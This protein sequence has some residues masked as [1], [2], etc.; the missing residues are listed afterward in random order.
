MRLKFDTFMTL[1]SQRIHRLCHRS[2]TW[3]RCFAE[4]IG[5]IEPETQFLRQRCRIDVWRSRKELVRLAWRTEK[6]TTGKFYILAC[7]G[8]CHETVVI[9]IWYTTHLAM[10]P[11][12]A[13][14]DSNPGIVAESGVEKVN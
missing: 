8:S 9:A 5:G 1:L 13:F 12:M 3:W 7:P 11:A 14:N 4:V 10:G 6:G 2:C